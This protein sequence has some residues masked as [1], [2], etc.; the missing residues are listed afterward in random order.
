MD[1]QKGFDTVELIYLDKV[2]ELFGF[3]NKFWQW[4]HIMKSNI[5]SCAINNAYSIS[6]FKITWGVRQG[7]PL[8]PYI[9][10]ILF[11]QLMDIAVRTSKYIQGIIEGETDFKIRQRADN[12]ICFF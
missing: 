11:V 4:V 7:C 2:I 3:G 10:F 1:F 5:T 8:S 9:F 12:T 6:F